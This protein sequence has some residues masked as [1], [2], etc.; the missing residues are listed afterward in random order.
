[1]WDKVLGGALR[2]WEGG[3]EGGP[4]PFCSRERS[5][6][7]RWGRRSG[8][9]RTEFYCKIKKK[10]QNTMTE[11]SMEIFKSNVHM[12]KTN[13]NTGVNLVRNGKYVDELTVKTLP[14]AM[15]HKS[16]W[17]LTAALCTNTW[18]SHSLFTC[19]CANW[20]VASLTSLSGCLEG[21]MCISLQNYIKNVSTASTTFICFIWYILHVT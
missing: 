20:V 8:W 3:R 10:G 12:D 17:S 14:E 18:R 19:V 21:K 13:N 15:K 16:T 11:M 9:I 5:G 7:I 4:L 6:N 1:M 2:R